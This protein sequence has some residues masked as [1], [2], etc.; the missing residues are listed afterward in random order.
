MKSS[1][2]NRPTRQPRCDMPPRQPD[3]QPRVGLRALEPE[4]LELLYALENAPETWGST[5][6]AA[7][8][9]RYALK[10][11]IASATGDIYADSQV[12]LVA[13]LTGPASTATPIGLADLTG[14]DPTNMRAEVGIILLPSYRGKGLGRQVLE[15]LAEY[16]RHLHLHQIWATV[17]ET[18]DACRA[19]MAAAGFSPTALLPQW[20]RTDD[21]YADARIWQRIID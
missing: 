14:F 12:R 5:S 7:F 18:N 16:A 10:Q 3:R 6:V 20:L 13:T 11:F 8:Y 9:S 21:G 2:D 4:D 15:C 1:A 17:A 19:T